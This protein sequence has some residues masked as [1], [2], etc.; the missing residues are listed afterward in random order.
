MTENDTYYA[1]ETTDIYTYAPT[2]ITYTYSFADD[3][4]SYSYE[5][6]FAFSPSTNL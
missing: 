5:T 3:L 1:Y 2:K 6:G 4:G